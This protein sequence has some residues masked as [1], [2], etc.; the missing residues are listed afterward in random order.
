MVIQ[1]SKQECQ[2]LDSCSPFIARYGQFSC[3]IGCVTLFNCFGSVTVTLHSRVRVFGYFSVVCVGVALMP[4][5]CVGGVR[6]VSLQHAS[7]P[8][9]AQVLSSTTLAPFGP[10]KQRMISVL[11]F[12]YGFPANLTSSVVAALYS[13]ASVL[14]VWVVL[15][16]A[17][18]LSWQ[19]GNSIIQCTLCTAQLVTEY[20]NLTSQILSIFWPTNLAPK[21]LFAPKPIFAPKSL[22]AKILIEM[23]LFTYIPFLKMLSPF[24]K[25]CILHTSPKVPNCSLLKF[26]ASK[27]VNLLVLQL[28]CF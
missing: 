24:P 16:T 3:L 17:P 13:T 4:L 25:E 20:R 21:S 23:V 22:F 14:L 12:G 28:V 7:V 27:F 2:I 6:C 11:I 26:D 19:Q 10:W 9:L 8:S 5:Y 15:A 1:V 18:S